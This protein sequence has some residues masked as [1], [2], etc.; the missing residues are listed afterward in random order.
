MSSHKIKHNQK[1]RKQYRK[2]QKSGILNIVKTCKHDHTKNTKNIIDN[3]MVHDTY[4]NEQLSLLSEK[5]KL[6]DIPPLIHN[7][8]FDNKESVDNYQEACVAYYTHSANKE[9]NKSIPFTTSIKCSCYFSNIID[10]FKLFPKVISD[11]IADYING[12][13]GTI[14]IYCNYNV[15]IIRAKLVH[16]ESE[17]RQFKMII[18]STRS[19]DDIC[20]TDDHVVIY[21]KPSTKISNHNAHILMLDAENHLRSILFGKN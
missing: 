2:K 16:N 13:S 9:F 17:C 21:Q 19:A 3:I 11:T 14:E 15:T 6:L 5:I 1:R 10:S 18:Y 12:I 7:I 4:V 8:D 20:C